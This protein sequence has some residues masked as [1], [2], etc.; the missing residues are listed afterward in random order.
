M[1]RLRTHFTRCCVRAPC[2]NPKQARAGHA[3]PASLRRKHGPSSNTT[4]QGCMHVQCSSL[5]TVTAGKRALYV[6]R[7]TA[8]LNAACAERGGGGGGGCAMHHRPQAA[9][10]ARHAPHDL[11]R[12][13]GGAGRDGRDRAKHGRHARRH[14]LGARGLRAR[15]QPRPRRQPPTQPPRPAVPETRA[16]SD[17]VGNEHALPHGCP[18]L[19]RTSVRGD[20]AC[21][22]QSLSVLSTAWTCSSYMHPLN[23]HLPL[24]S[25][26]AASRLH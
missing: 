24:L 1:R 23:L 9:G 17:R 13:A 26:I 18:A 14:I 10:R 19:R 6:S 21:P 4:Q 12:E 5:P 22:S 25:L 20:R 16:P 2:G 11:Q 7:S 15:T 3:E 8:L